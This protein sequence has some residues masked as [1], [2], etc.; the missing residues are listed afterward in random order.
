MGI[1]KEEIKL[2]FSL[3]SLN[4]HRTAGPGMHKAEGS[5]VS[6][7]IRL[8]NAVNRTMR[9]QKKQRRDRVWESLQQFL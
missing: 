4:V 7:I 6:V 3:N 1:I 5:C 2:I 8:C 9:K